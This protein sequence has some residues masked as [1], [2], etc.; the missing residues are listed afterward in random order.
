[1]SRRQMWYATFSYRYYY[2]YKTKTNNRK[3][4]EF[5]GSSDELFIEG[6]EQKVWDKILL[7]LGDSETIRY[8]LTEKKISNKKDVGKTVR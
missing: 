6:E 5:S 3:Y 2:Q 4:G 7:E 1:M 8:T